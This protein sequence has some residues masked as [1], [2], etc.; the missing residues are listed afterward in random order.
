MLSRLF[1]KHSNNIYIFTGD[2][3]QL[4]IN[5]WKSLDAVFYLLKMIQV[6]VDRNKFLKVGRLQWKHL[7]TGLDIQFWMI[8]VLDLCG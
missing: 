6:K 7:L 4:C 3:Y 2:V 8:S 1:K 5:W